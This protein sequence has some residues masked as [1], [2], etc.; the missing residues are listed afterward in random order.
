MLAPDD[1]EIIVKMD[2]PPKQ[3]PG[4]VM[5]LTVGKAD[6]HVFDAETG[7]RVD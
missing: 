1:I 4:D 3:A 2:E 7:Q 5:H 6:Y